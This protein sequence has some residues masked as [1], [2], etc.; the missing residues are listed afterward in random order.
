MH[1]CGNAHTWWAQSEKGWKGSCLSFT[2]EVTNLWE[3]TS[4]ERIHWLSWLLHHCLSICTIKPTSSKRELDVTLG[5]KNKEHKT[6][7][8]NTS[9]RHSVK[10]T[11]WVVLQEIRQSKSTHCSTEQLTSNCRVKETTKKGSEPI[12]S[13]WMEVVELLC[14]SRQSALSSLNLAV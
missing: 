12:H 8:P 14:S 10:A 1:I 2:S 6:S 11:C 7:L 3:H 9:T 5:L 4:E 13:V